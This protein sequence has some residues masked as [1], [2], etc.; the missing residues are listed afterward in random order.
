MPDK[1]VWK[2]LYPSGTNS[3]KR[4]E[5]I[6]YILLL[7]KKKTLGFKLEIAMGDRSIE[8]VDYDIAIAR[9]SVLDFA[10]NNAHE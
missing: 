1:S 2:T 9:I 6:V 5:T 3:I 7:Y 10:Q 4:N 8:R